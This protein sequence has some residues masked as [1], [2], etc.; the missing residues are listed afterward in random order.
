[1]LRQRVVVGIRTLM[2]SFIHRQPA[3]GAGAGKKKSSTAALDG[4][5]GI[6]ALFVFCFHVLFSYT[7]AI[8]Y[9]YG[10]SEANQHIVQLPFLS[11]F[12]RGH[13]MVAVFFVVGGYVMSIKPLSL[14]HSHQAAAAPGV[15]V[16][17]VFRRGI[18]LYLP[19]IAATFVTM[20]T[21]YFGLWEYPRQFVTGDEQLIVYSDLHPL[22]KATLASQFWDWL[23]EVASMTDLFYYYNK[24]GFLLPYYNKYDPHLWTVPFEYRSSLIVTVVL[25]ALSRCKFAVR[26]FLTGLI[27]LFC[28]FWDRWEVVC[29]LA[30]MILC[31]IDL[32]NQKP[33]PRPARLETIVEEDEDLLPQWEAK[34]RLALEDSATRNGYVKH[35]LLLFLAGLY[36]LSTPNLDIGNTPGY[37]TLFQLTPSTYSDKKRFLQSLGAICTV[38]AITNCSALQSPF[39]TSFAQ[40]LGSISYSLYIVHGPLIHIVGYSI[41]P[42]I[43]I[44]FT[45]KEGLNWIAGLILGSGILAAFVVITA[46]I[47]WRHVDLKSIAIARY[48]ECACFADT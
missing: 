28:G 37:Q 12:Y 10:Q 3:L 20:C 29:F 23:N 47:F 48:L 33:E 5:R 19:A 1:M 36:L 45:G 30:G 4:L 6:A 44:H 40:Y 21:V 22:P 42:N 31:D 41:T 35:W 9:G 8:E 34:T 38:W 24:N 17:S 25:L 2:P 32:F 11:L 26:L 16:S 46:D 14:M 15:L 13:S 43:W 39:V 7:T 18:R 27:V